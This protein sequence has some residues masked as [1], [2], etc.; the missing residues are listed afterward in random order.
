LSGSS[1]AGL[2]AVVVVEAAS[3]VVVAEAASDLQQ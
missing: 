3:A 2:G 1:S